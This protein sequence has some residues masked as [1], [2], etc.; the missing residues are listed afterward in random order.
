MA[1]LSK[2]EMIIHLAAE[3]DNVPEHLLISQRRRFCHAR[4]IVFYLTYSLTDYSLPAIGQM[5]NKDHTTILHGVRAILKEC[6]EDPIFNAWIR[7][8]ESLIGHNRHLNSP[9]QITKMPR[10]KYPRTPAIP[11]EPVS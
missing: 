8:C 3:K 5:F 11:L 4:F 1:D 6:K 7:Q 2:V 10:K 9:D